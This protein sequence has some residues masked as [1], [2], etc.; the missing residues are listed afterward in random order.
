MII[1]T[2]T[3]SITTPSMGFM[4]TMEIIF[5]ICFIIG[6]MVSMA[7]QYNAYRKHD[8]PR[9]GAML[10]RIGLAIVAFS[11]LLNIS[12]GSTLSFFLSEQL[13]LPYLL[14]SGVAAMFFAGGF[15]FMLAGVLISRVTHRTVKII[16]DDDELVV[17]KTAGPVE[18]D[19]VGH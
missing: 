13:G 18:A 4:Q 12:I 17:D 11:F 2:A 16:V 3:G 6:A 1:F 7:K 19:L 10:N 8:K 9:L 15:F 14:P 5:M